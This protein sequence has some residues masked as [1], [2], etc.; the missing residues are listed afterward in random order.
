MHVALRSRLI[1]ERFASPQLQALMRRRLAELGGLLL[2]GLA[3]AMLVAL[4]SYNPRDPSPDTATTVQT[5][6]LAGPVGAAYAD[7][8]LQYFGLAGGL[9]VLALLAWAWR[10][11]SRGGLG[12]LMVRLVSLLCAL[13][14]AAAVLAGLP[15]LLGH[16]LLGPGMSGPGMS[17]HDAQPELRPGWPGAAGPGGAV[18]VTLG[19]AAIEA[20]RG[21]LGPVGGIAIWLMALL[22]A[23][24]LVPLC[25]GL[26]AANGVRWD[27]GRGAPRATAWRGAAAA[28]KR[29]RPQEPAPASTRTRK[30]STTCFR[31]SP[32]SR[33][34]FARPA[35]ACTGPSRRWP[36]AWPT[37]RP[38]AAARCAPSGASPACAAGG[39]SRSRRVR[40]LATAAGCCRPVR[41][42]S[43]TICL[44]CRSGRA[45]R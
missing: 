16:E 14:V 44:C 5:S 11:A 8:M 18:G 27:A 37:P 20:G 43:R 36:T 29:P 13:P 23:L 31:A 9:P 45:A 3:I 25:L 6:N 33:R 38:S 41:P 2:A 10:I 30:S 22:L 35:A 34:R 40:R 1:P 28:G 39:L 24:V 4:A 15:V 42:R 21:V 12:S 26:S 7:L 32:R 19:R 17:G